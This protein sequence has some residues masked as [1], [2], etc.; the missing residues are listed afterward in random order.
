MTMFEVAWRLRSRLYDVCEGSELRRGPAKSALFRQMAG[1]V[2]FVAIGTGTDI[3]HFPAGQDITAIDISREMLA[4]A[5]SRQRAYHGTLRLVQANALA[6]PFADASFDTAITS[7]TLCSVPDPVRALRELHRVLRPE[8]RLLMFEHVRS[9]NPLLGLMLDIMTLWTRLGGTD[10]NRDTLRNVRA[11]GFRITRTESVYL[12]IILTVHAV[13]TAPSLARP[14]SV[15]QRRLCVPE[16][17]V[18]P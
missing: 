14:R 4:K 9:R 13:K 16:S 15:G 11:A 17:V 18:N 6:L 7:C 2:L 3:R 1:R 8:G 12:D 10:M 5:A